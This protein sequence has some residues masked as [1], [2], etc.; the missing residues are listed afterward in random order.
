MLF[1][2][3]PSGRWLIYVKPRL[4]LNSF[5]NEA[6]SYEGIGATKKWERIFSYGP[7]FVENIVQ[8]VSRDLLCFALQRVHQEGFGIVMHVHDEIVVEAPVDVT[9]EQINRLMSEAPDW[10]KHL[11]LQGDGF[12]TNFYKKD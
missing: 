12:E 2:G 11:N 9:V 10:A 1:I 4:G 7:K 3:L 6:V 8:A 5:G